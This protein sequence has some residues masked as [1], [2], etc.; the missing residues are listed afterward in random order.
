MATIP[1]ST[2]V[3]TLFGHV[4]GAFTGANQRH[5]GLFEQAHGGTLFLDEIGETPAEIQPMLL[6]VL[7]TGT[8]TPL[9]DTREVAVDVRVVAATDARLEL[10]VERGGFRRA[11]LHRLGGY[12]IDVPPLRERRDDIAPL[13]VRF[14][15]Q[16]LLDGDRHLLTVDPRSEHMPIPVSS[17]TRLLAHPFAGNVRELRNLARRLAVSSRDEPRLVVESVHERL[18]R[19]RPA[20]A[21]PLAGQLSGQ[22]G[23]PIG[24][25]RGVRPAD[26][27]DAVLVAALEQ[28]DW[29][30]A[31]AAEALGIAKSTVQELMRKSPNIRLARDI[32]DAELQQAA[33]ECNGDTRVMAARLRVS[34]RSLRKT[35]RERG[36]L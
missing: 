28:N 31:R 22:A 29:S 18:A 5:A 13:F 9:G 7:E 36:L 6:R 30:A 16:E 26:L 14:L 10:E 35:M 34:E 2:A 21:T 24:V 4:R 19:E 1:P 17:M 8:L 32:D 3:S 23:P 25:G 12:E 20:S 33:S 15:E 11:L 27:D